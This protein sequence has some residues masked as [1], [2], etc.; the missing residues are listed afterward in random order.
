MSR[1]RS[2][3][4]SGGNTKTAVLVGVGVGLLA[5]VGYFVAGIAL[6][7]WTL[8]GFLEHH[9]LRE[10]GLFLLADG[11]AVAVVAIPLVAYLRFRAILPL[12]LFG[13]VVFVWTVVGA[14]QGRTT[15]AFFELALEAAWYAPVYLVLYFAVVGIELA[16]QHS[17]KI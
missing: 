4:Q 3:G 5:V 6:E 7:L 1:A 17:S 16:L 8:R 11:L 12:L 9:T 2:G 14:A 15:A 13:L 10:F